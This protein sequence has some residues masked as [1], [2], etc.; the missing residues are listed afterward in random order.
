MVLATIGDALE[1]EVKTCLQSDPVLGMAL[2]GLGNA[3]L[4]CLTAFA[5]NLVCEQYGRTS[6]PINP[7]LVGWDLLAGQQQIFSALQAGEAG[8]QLL[9][10]GQMLPLKSVSLVLGVGEHVLQ[11]GERC[12]YCSAQSTCRYQARD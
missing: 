4:E 3:A 2:D 6:I 10:S 5:C 1:S 12:D 11:E 7:G 9:P 8:I